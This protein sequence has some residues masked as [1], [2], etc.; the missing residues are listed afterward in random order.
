MIS[1]PPADALEIDVAVLGDDPVD[2]GIRES[3]RLDDL[4]PLGEGLELALGAEP[5]VRAEGAASGGEVD[6]G[7]L[8]GQGAESV[9]E[10]SSRPACEMF[11]EGAHITM[12]AQTEV[13]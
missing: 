8:G 5:G 12:R 11:S 6:V 10:R 1:F 13:N 9:R 4:E 3:I 7:Y 2:D